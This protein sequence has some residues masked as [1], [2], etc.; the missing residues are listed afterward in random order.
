M[1]GTPH[2]PVREHPELEIP[3]VIAR[4]HIQQVRRVGE[5]NVVVTRP[6]RQQVIDVV[7]SGNIRDRRGDVSLGVNAR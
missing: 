4:E 2:A 7:E 1:L 6:V 5:V 3:N